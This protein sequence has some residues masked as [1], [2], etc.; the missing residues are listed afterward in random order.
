MFQKEHLC[1]E[2]QALLAVGGCLK[3]ARESA[4][5]GSAAHVVRSRD[6]AAVPAKLAAGTGVLSATQN[7]WVYLEPLPLRREV[8]IQQRGL[9]PPGRLCQARQGWSLRAAPSQRKGM[10][11][12]ASRG[13]GL[14]G[15]R[16][17]QQ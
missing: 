3:G 14:P 10:W 17:M 16:I 4:S 12:R 11:D 7:Q 9:L 2:A 1:T 8:V 5:K 13:K 6:A 15:Q